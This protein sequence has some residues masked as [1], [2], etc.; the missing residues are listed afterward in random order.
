MNRE[1]VNNVLEKAK[2]S[3][4]SDDDYKRLDFLADLHARVIKNYCNRPSWKGV[5][6]M[7]LV[8][9]W[10]PKKNLPGNQ[11]SSIAMDS[12][13]SR[14]EIYVTTLDQE[15][16]E[17]PFRELPEGLGLIFGAQEHGGVNH[18][19]LA[20]LDHPNDDDL[21]NSAGGGTS[22]ASLLLPSSEILG[23]RNWAAVEP[24]WS[25]S[26]HMPILAGVTQ[27]GREADVCELAAAAL[28][29]VVV[30]DERVQS[31]REDIVRG[32][33]LFK[34]WAQVGVWCPMHPED[35]EREEKPIDQKQ[36]SHDRHKACDLDHPDFEDIQD[37]LLQPTRLEHQFPADFIVIHLTILEQ[38][39]SKR[40][41]SKEHSK[42]T[43]NETLSALLD[44]TACK[45]AERI[46]VTGRGVPTVARFTD[47]NDRLDARFVPISA[48]QEYLVTR[49]SK[50]GLMRVLWASAAPRRSMEREH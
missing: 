15:A 42:E 16:D 7:L 49:P 47:G 50:L 44:G 13:D 43:L 48:V 39:N 37:Y 3:A 14:L 41:L 28:G 1:E 40:R 38:L 24:M 22:A 8:V 19:G 46:V 32:V 27:P 12:T 26:V 9:A 17:T 33:T 6:K 11:T 10:D 45:Q 31:R 35:F 29:R 4:Q 30:L 25:A 5:K 20:W 18:L 34:Y 2:A 21:L 23:F 36:V